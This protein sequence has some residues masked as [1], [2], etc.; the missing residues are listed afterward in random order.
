MR[1]RP[2]SKTGGLT[3]HSAT[4]GRCVAGRYN[5]RYKGCAVSG[6]QHGACDQPK[7]RLCLP[8]EAGCR[9]GNQQRPLNGGKQQSCSH[10]GAFSTH[11]NCATASDAR[12]G[13]RCGQRRQQARMAAPCYCGACACNACHSRAAADGACSPF[14][15]CWAIAAPCSCC[16]VLLLRLLL[17]AVCRQPHELPQPSHA[18]AHAVWDLQ[19]R[20][21]YARVGHWLRRQPTEGNIKRGDRA[22]RRRAML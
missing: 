8:A 5:R 18:L 3:A 1:C 9:P 10:C 20:A 6:R 16:A 12:A 2:S 4:S 19:Q 14:A 7:Q 11:C 15:L 21:Q 13:Y 17:L 22:H